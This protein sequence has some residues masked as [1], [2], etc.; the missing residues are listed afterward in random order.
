MCFRVW[1]EQGR[2]FVICILQQNHIVFH[3]LK[4]KK[5]RII[6]AWKHENAPKPGVNHSIC[7]ATSQETEYIPKFPFLFLT[8]EP[9]KLLLPY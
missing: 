3:S 5:E 7:I 4:Y 8:G 6:T 1:N 2:S 9:F